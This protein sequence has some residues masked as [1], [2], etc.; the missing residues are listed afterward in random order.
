MVKHCEVGYRAG[1]L[2]PGS[3]N[4]EELRLTVLELRVAELK[5]VLNQLS[6]PNNG[7]KLVL[8]TRIFN[9]FGESYLGQPLQ[10]EPVKE[11]WKR[12]AAS[13]AKTSSST[14]FFANC[15]V[16]TFL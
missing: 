5:S 4:A 7:K 8:Q 6:L 12:Q 11:E 9:Y 14:I 15:W 2:P 1:G 3:M 10:I 13:K 16:Q